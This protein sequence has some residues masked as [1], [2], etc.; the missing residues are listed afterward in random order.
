MGYPPVDQWSI[1][2]STKF[3]LRSEE[4]RKRD[5]R[6]DG[7]DAD[8]DEDFDERDSNSASHDCLRDELKSPPK[9]LFVT[10]FR[11]HREHWLP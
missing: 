11:M 9:E 3:L 4:R 8:D 10:L 2:M 5:G 1:W 7:D 6:N